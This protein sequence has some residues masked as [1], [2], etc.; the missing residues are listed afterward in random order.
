MKAQQRIMD[1]VLI[2]RLSLQFTPAGNDLL[3][4]IQR[5][6]ETLAAASADGLTG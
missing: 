2:E 6:D 1:I 4:A 5:R 3:A